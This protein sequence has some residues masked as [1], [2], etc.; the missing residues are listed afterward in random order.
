MAL[1]QFIRIIMKQIEKRVKRYG[2]AG[3]VALACIKCCQCCLLCFEK[4]LK[5][6]NKNAYIEVG[7][8]NISFVIM[9]KVLY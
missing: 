6:I 2:G 5:Y 7:K 8:L 9:E 3:K 4:V 1:I